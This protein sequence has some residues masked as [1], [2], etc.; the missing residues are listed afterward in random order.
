MIRF[1]IWTRVGREGAR[2][3]AEAIVADI[4]TIRAGDPEQKYYTRYRDAHFDAQVKDW[5]DVLKSFGYERLA[6]R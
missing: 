3:A 6:G 2:A 1:N 5:K 4:E